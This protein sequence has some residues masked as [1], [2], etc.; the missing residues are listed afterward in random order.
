M[1]EAEGGLLYDHQEYRCFSLK[2]MKPDVRDCKQK[3][4][5]N[6]VSDSFSF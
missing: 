6:L 3:Q 2:L 4:E 5:R 1:S